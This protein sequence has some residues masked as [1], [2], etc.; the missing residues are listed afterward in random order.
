MT[1]RDF[2]IYWGEKTGVK[3]GESKSRYLKD[4]ESGLRNRCATCHYFEVTDIDVLIS[5]LFLRRP[6]WVP[7]Y[8]LGI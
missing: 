1:L 4:S 6:F 8:A 5:V 2:P 3:I 7:P